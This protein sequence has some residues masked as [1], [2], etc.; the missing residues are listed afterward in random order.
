MKAV[1]THAALGDRGRQRKGLSQRRR[2]AMK[3]GVEGGDLRQPGP[4]RGDG[5]DRHQVVRLMQRRQRDERSQLLDDG[6]V[7]PHRRSVIGAAVHDAVSN[8]GEPRAAR[9]GLQPVEQ[10]FKRA[11]MLRRRVF[12]P[13]VPARDGASRIPRAKPRPAVKL[14]QVPTQLR[15]ELAAVADEIHGEF[16]AR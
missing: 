1:A 13:V 10:E 4:P 9:R 7:H 8:R 6:C 5:A 2:G 3:C 12:A 11:L 14:L 15:F 16:Q